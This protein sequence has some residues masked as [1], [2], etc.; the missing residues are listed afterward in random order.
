MDKFQD[1]FRIPSHRL[2]NWDYSKN[3]IYF[4][5]IVVQNRECI[6]GD[7]ENQ[8]MEL[9]DFGKIVND[10]WVTSFEIRN[11]LFP[12]EFVIMSNHLHG[13]V[14]LKNPINFVGSGGVV[15]THD[16]A[17][18]PIQND[19]RTPM[20]QR[21]PKSISSFIA[22]FK[23][24]TTIQI[25]NYIDSKNLTIS[26]YNRENKLWQANYHDHILRNE[27]EYWKIKNYIRNNPANWDNDK[28]NE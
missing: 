20:P 18:L 19:G 21:K 17:S 14:V 9:S 1:R 7:I 15:E 10:E 12:D 26:K 16:R 13:L 22:G 2:K 27:E 5:I 4:I 25:D 8:K 3:G 24:A 6:L 28:F 11:E 23:S